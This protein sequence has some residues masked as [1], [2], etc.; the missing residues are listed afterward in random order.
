MGGLVIGEEEIARYRHGEI[1]HRNGLI[2]R[3][4]SL[5]SRSD[6]LV[7]DISGFVRRLVHNG[8]GVVR[9]RG[10]VVSRLCVRKHTEPLLVFVAQRY[11]EGAQQHLGGCCLLHTRGQ[12]VLNNTRRVDNRA[13]L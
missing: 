3:R 12:F 6:R 2:N 13:V 8:D 9:P 10:C 11:R 5:I 7:G 4:D 1:P